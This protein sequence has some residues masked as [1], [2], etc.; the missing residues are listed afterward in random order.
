[1]KK[2]E[3]FESQLFFKIKQIEKKQLF[4]E[5]KRKIK[6]SSTNEKIENRQNKAFFVLNFYEKLTHTTRFKLKKTFDNILSNYP[7]YHL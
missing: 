2:L 5:R 4:W 1:M 3:V 7:I 6:I